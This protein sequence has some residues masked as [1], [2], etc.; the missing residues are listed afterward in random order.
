[1]KSSV[2]TKVDVI[3]RLSRNASITITTIARRRFPT[4]SA[5]SQ[6]SSSCPIVG[7]DTAATVSVARRRGEDGAFGV[8]IYSF[9]L[10]VPHVDF[11]ELPA[12]WDTT[13]SKVSI[14]ESVAE[15]DTDIEGV[16]ETACYTR[17]AE[18]YMVKKYAE[19]EEFWA[20]KNMKPSWTYFGA[21]DG[22]FRSIPALHQADCG[23]FDP[24]RRPWFVAASSG[25]KDVVLII[26]VSQSMDKSPRINVTRDAAATIVDT[27]TVAD[28]FIVIAFSTEA[29]SLGDYPSLIPATSDNKEKLK[30]AIYELEPNGTTN[31]HAAFET[32][33]DA[34]DNTIHNEESSDGRIA[35]LFMTDGKIMEAGTA[36]EQKNET[37]RVITLVNE[38]TA[39]LAAIRR[40][41]TIFTYSLGEDSDHDVVKS[42]ACKTG[43][44]WTPVDDYGDLVAEMS[45]YYKLF[46][47]GLGEGENKDAVA[48]VEPYRFFT[49]GVV[50]TTVSVP[51]YDRN[52]TPHLFLGGESNDDIVI[53]GLMPFQHRLITVQYC[54]SCCRGH[55]HGYNRSRPR[56]RRNGLAERVDYVQTIDY[57]REHNAG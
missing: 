15:S 48:W 4:R 18:P 6:M 26:D 23:T 8:G 28:R 31:F 46:A 17:L 47:L 12:L 33:F 38:R 1:M 55:L 34:L 43:G 32:A 37:S 10:I 9:V 7:M 42:I 39:R 52:V 30:K 14:P 20:K 13:S 11:H 53:S 24:R 41:V 50:G 5:S 29:Y 22:L 51:V 21:H 2:S 45:S 36:E 27:L 49:R 35:V 56:G 57:R 3:A 54:D 40:K 16:V 44:V 25:P 19:S